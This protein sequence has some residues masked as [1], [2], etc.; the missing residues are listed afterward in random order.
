M[1]R[2]QGFR[3]LHRIKRKKSI[4]KNRFFRAGILI[5]IFFI[6]VF[7]LLFFSSVFQ[8]NSIAISGEQ[9]VVKQDIK[10]VIE[11]Q[12]QTKF[13][14][15]NTKSVFLINHKEVKNSV[16]EKFPLINTFEMSRKLPNSLF[17]IVVERIEVAKWSAEDKYFLIDNSGIIFQEIFETHSSLPTIKSFDSNEKTL[18]QRV[19]EKETLRNVLQ[20]IS[21]LKQ[22]LKIQTKLAD[23]VSKERLDIETSENWEIYFNLLGD[24]DW[25]ITELGLILEKEIDSEKRQKL[26]YIDLRFNRVFYK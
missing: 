18:G 11:E 20:I 9:E 22:N 4:L 12:I 21:K 6:S 24:I 14:F 25:Q 26:E 23:I 2:S 3:K 8:I 7:Y 5:L 19:V 10:N 17:V 16:L 13:F 1:Q 15:F